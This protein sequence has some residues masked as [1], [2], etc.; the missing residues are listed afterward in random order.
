M[1]KK[2]KELKSVQKYYVQV[3]SFRISQEKVYY[4]LI[5][6]TKE[7]IKNNHGPKST[8]IKNVYNSMLHLD[9]KSAEDAVKYTIE[10]I[11]KYIEDNDL[12][13]L[14][15]QINQNETI[16]WGCPIV[17]SVMKDEKHSDTY[18]SNI[19][20]PQL[21]VYDYV[22]YIEDNTAD[23]MTQKYKRIFKSKFYKKSQSIFTEGYGK[24]SGKNFFCN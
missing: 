12:Y 6:I 16:S 15:G 19:S 3:D 17:W 18:R 1:S 4:E 5:D 22:I 11:D 13:K 20:Q 9:E 24:S 8:Q 10:H 23:Q 21:T 7:H 2:G 14:L